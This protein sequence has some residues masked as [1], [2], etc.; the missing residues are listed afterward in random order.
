MR[1]RLHVDAEA[2]GLGH[3]AHRHAQLRA[4]R[5]LVGGDQREV[6]AVRVAGLG[7]QLLGLGD[8]GLA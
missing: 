6:E 1:H 2:G 7:E 3:L 8:V 5:R 4:G